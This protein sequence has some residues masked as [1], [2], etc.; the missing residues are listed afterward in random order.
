M[1]PAVPASCRTGETEARGAEIRSAPSGTLHQSKSK[2]IP[3]GEAA[4]SFRPEIPF[5]E[6]QHRCG[7]AANRTSHA[8][9][10]DSALTQHT[11]LTLH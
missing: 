3:L 4:S 1:P 9:E 7:R 11:W 6:P 10:A 5:P 8:A 2:A